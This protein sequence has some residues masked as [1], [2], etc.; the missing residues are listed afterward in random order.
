MGLRALK[1]GP[2]RQQRPDDN[3]TAKAQRY[4]SVH[5]PVVAPCSRVSVKILGWRE[6]ACPLSQQRPGSDANVARVA[7]PL[8]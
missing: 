5:C 7:Q 8:C 2:K 3:L 4:I 1:P 6:A